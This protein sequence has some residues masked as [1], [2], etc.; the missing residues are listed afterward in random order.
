MGIEGPDSQCDGCILMDSVQVVG[1]QERHSGNRTFRPFVSSPPRRFALW[2]YLTF[3]SH[4]IH[5][6]FYHLRLT[7]FI[8]AN[9]GDDPAYSVKPKHQG[10]NVDGRTAEW[11][12]RP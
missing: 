6:M 11:A 8:T 4:C 9:D 7:T 10:R 12:K 1:E 2:T 3:S 5:F